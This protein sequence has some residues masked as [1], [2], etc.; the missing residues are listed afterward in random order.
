MNL[1]HEKWVRDDLRDRSHI[2]HALK[3]FDENIEAGIRRFRDGELSAW[4]IADSQWRARIKVW[5]RNPNLWN[6]D[7]WGP[8][9]GAEGCR[10]PHSILA[11]VRA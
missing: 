1:M 5:S 4:D 7:M 11:E 10:A 8:P 9:P 6:A 2:P 3:V